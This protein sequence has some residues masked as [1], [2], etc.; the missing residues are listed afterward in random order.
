MPTAFLWPHVLELND[1]IGQLT[2]MV[3][4]MIPINIGISVWQNLEFMTASF[5]PA[6]HL[7]I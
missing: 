6:S 7:L 3:L 5:I 1:S 4:L 2:W